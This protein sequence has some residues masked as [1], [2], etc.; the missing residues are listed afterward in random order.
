MTNTNE[1]LI[2]PLGPVMCDIEGLTLSD[3]ERNRL[4][5]PSVGAVILFSRNYRDAQQVADL[6]RDIKSL[7]SPA[8]LVAVD[9]EGGRVQRFKNG[10]TTLPPAADFGELWRQDKHTAPMRAFES[11]YTMASELLAVG[12][13]F[14]FAPVFD[15]N[16]EQ[17]EVIGDRCFHPD[18]V[19]ATELLG[20]YIDGMHAAGMVAIAKHFPGHGGVAGDSHQ[21]LP[22]DERSLEQLKQRDLLPYQRLV[23]EI[24]GVMTAHVLFAE[25]A[26]EI[27]TYSSFWLQNVLRG[28]LQFDGVIFSDDLSMQGAIEA[29]DGGEGNIVASAQR[30]IYAGCDM[31]LVCNQPQLVDELLAGLEFKPNQSLSAR[32]NALSAA[33]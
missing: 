15:V 5:H 12:V 27:P 14:S 30:A 11:A 19:A 2:I 21:C 23:D 18:P 1:Q 9:Q 31:V 26:D 16:S 4:Q 6:I 7:R 28:E 8:L 25:C 24:Q 20:A 17:N 13:D 33:R 22:T 32:L 3:A 10:F 29:N